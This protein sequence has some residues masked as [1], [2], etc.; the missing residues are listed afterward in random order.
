MN[1]I[2]AEVDGDGNPTGDYVKTKITDEFILK[3]TFPVQS[4][5]NGSLVNNRLNLDY[6]DLIEDIQIGVT[7]RQKIGE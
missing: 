4:Y 3:V 6:A 2:V 5:V 7:A 1:T